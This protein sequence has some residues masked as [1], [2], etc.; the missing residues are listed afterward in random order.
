M[1]EEGPY[2]LLVNKT[3]NVE[4]L[5]D[6]LKTKI[7]TPVSAAPSPAPAPETPKEAP[8]DSDVEMKDASEP[9]APADA[10]AAS[11]PATPVPVP[12]PA[13]A[14]AEPEPHG[15]GELRLIEV[16]N[17][18]VSRV[19]SNNEPVKSLND[20]S[21]FYAEEIP[22][23]HL[24]LAEGDQLVPCFHFHKDPYSSHGIPFLFLLK[25]VSFF[26]LFLFVLSFGWLISLFVFPSSLKGE[27]WEKTVQRLRKRMHA[28]EKEFEKYKFALVSFGKS[29]AITEGSP[30]FF[31]CS[32]PREKPLNL[33]HFCHAADIVLAE[34]KFGANDY[35][36]VDHVDKA[37]KTTGRGER[38]IVF[39]N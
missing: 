37:P 2:K 17:N 20:Y 11:A 35:L 12:V 5:L 3:D 26:V 18:R 33:C 8:K 29:K 28:G 38:S 19:F 15:T 30:L 25:A 32:F 23:D 13:A 10:D 7:K 4:H 1:V 27:H 22:S 36:G 39:R 14:A 21:T 24:H 16:F 31:P 34:T 9:A 6:I